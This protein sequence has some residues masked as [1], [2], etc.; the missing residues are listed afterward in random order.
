VLPDQHRQMEPRGDAK[1]PAQL[2]DLFGHRCTI[3]ADLGSDLVVGLPLGNQP[4]DGAL[5][6]AQRGQARS[7]HART[8]G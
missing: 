7:G 4:R 2:L 8:E 6:A 1:C 3:E 5:T